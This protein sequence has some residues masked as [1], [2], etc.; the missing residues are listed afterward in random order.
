[1]NFLNKLVL[2]VLLIGL[3][4]T[5]FGTDALT[6]SCLEDQVLELLRKWQQGDLLTMPL[7]SLG[8]IRLQSYEGQYTGYGIK[9][10]Y[11]TGNMNMTGL[12][13]FKVKELSASTDDLFE[14]SGAISIPSLT[15]NSDNYNLKGNAYVF[16][17]LKGAG[18]MNVTFENVSLTFS[19]SLAHNANKKDRGI[20]IDD[21]QLNYSVDAIRV[22]LEN[23][24]WPVNKVLNAEA[25]SIN[26]NYRSLLVNA[27]TE[28]LKKSLNSYLITVPP[29]ALTYA[30]CNICNK[31]C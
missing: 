5:I 11:T 21:I 19:I 2:I 6:P 24:S 26:E 9:I 30:F 8:T 4:P 25:K 3:S 15:L 13:N 28:G 7:P 16:Y 12:R 14:A 17:S 18:F 27:A 1:M 23:C 20:E 29:T 10:A 31:K 22:N